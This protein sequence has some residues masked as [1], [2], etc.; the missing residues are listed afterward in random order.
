METRPTPG[1]CESFWGDAGIGQIFQ[2]RD[3]HGGRC[4]GDRQN[5]RVG[6]IDLVIDRRV[7]QIGRQQVVGG[8]D[9]GLHFLF[10]HIQCLGKRELQGHDGDAFGTGGR[11]LFQSRHL[12][13]LPLERRRD[14][15]GDDFRAGA[16]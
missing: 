7:R 2:F 3:R 10:R 9:R 16:G 11:H 8:V 6:R 14:R 13:E 5:R 4:D 15:R 1:T 12:A